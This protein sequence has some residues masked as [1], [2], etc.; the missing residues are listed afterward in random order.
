MTEELLDGADVRAAFEQVGGEAVPQGVGGRPLVDAGQ[1]AG[2]PESTAEVGL[3]EVMASPHTGARV[4]RD[5]ARREYVLP[6]P[7]GR[8]AVA[9]PGYLRARASGT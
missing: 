5:P 1:L 3:V 4:A 9:A 6:F 7:G 8:R 2:L